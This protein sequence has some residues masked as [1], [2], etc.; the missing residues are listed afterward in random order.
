MK[1]RI[2]NISIALVAILVLYGAMTSNRAK[3][4]IW[5]ASKNG[6]TIY[7]VGT[8]HPGKSN[9]NYN[10]RILNKLMNKTDALAVEIDVTNENNIKKLD[11]DEKEKMYLKYGEIKDVLSNKEKI[12]FEKILKELDLN[13][14]DI[15]N[16]TPTG[17]LSCINTMIANEAKMEPLGSEGFMINKYK[18]KNKVITELENN[19]IQEEV[20]TFDE[21]HLKDFVNAFESKEDFFKEETGHF[22]NIVKYY[23]KGDEAYFLDTIEI[24]ETQSNKERNIKMADKIDKLARGNKKYLASAGVYHFFGKYSILENL[25]DK[26]YS[27]KKL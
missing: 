8:L 19:E 6:K 17:F 1:K 21:D 3:G 4:F 16:L 24:S 15:K 20:L 9:V 12:K 14:D 2:F 27:I 25:K 18:A 22:N 10:N 11:K 7:L 26:G 5:E 23:I 13:Y